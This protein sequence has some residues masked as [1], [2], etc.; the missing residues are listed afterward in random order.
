[1]EWAVEIFLHA[2][3]CP[4][5]S[6]AQGGPVFHPQVGS[7]GT[8]SLPIRIDLL[9]PSIG[10][11][12]ADERRHHLGFTS[13]STNILWNGCLFKPSP[14]K[15]IH[16][17]VGLSEPPSTAVR[18]LDSV[19]FWRGIEGE[20]YCFARSF[21]LWDKVWTYHLLIAADTKPSWLQT[22]T[23]VQKNQ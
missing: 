4:I 15:D 20:N 11:R 5:W 1:M 17:E 6:N 22:I 18:G 12:K 19:G 3:F 8:T 2:A 13:Q 16:N 7:D 23:L 14:E 9:S 21:K 10:D